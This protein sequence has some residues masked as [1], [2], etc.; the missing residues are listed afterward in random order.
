MRDAMGEIIRG[1]VRSEIG[2]GVRPAGTNGE[3]HGEVHCEAHGVTVREFITS[4]DL[5]SRG[6]HNE[7]Y[8]MVPI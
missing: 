8:F 2:V 7:V 3:V 1:R 5:M 4:A 6:A